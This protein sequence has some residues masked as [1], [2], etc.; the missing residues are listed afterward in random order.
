MGG[1]FLYFIQSYA[2]Y[3]IGSKGLQIGFP[4]LIGFLFAHGVIKRP[5]NGRLKYYFC[6]LA[7]FVNV[8]P[9]ELISMVAL[10]KVLNLGSTLASTTCGK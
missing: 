1:C 4:K 6:N 9:L 2:F 10:V 8:K 7:L 5:Q 3:N